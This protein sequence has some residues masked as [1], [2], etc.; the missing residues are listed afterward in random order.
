MTLPETYTGVSGVGT[1]TLTVNSNIKTS[2]A[3]FR[4]L[5]VN[6]LNDCKAV[7]DHSGSYKGDALHSLGLFKNE[8]PYIY[9]NS[10]DNFLF[11]VINY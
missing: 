3:N 5:V 11:T 1:D 7:F 4:C 10:E 8:A 2:S 9:E 6:K